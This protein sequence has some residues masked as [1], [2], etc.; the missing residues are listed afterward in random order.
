M[1]NDA[2]I[3]VDLVRETFLWKTSFFLMDLS[4]KE[5]L[6]NLMEFVFARFVRL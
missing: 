5:P 4:N 2:I 1:F 6:K 3:K